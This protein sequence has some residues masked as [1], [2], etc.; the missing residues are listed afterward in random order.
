MVPDPLAISKSSD[1]QRFD[2]DYVPL[3]PVHEVVI[4]GR[5]YIRA[6]C[7]QL[8]SKSLAL[9]LIWV[10]AHTSAGTLNIG[11]CLVCI[12]LVK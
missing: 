6:S 5:Q 4:S 3:F 10:P 2:A 1:V 11:S 8:A 9:C 12:Q 7:R